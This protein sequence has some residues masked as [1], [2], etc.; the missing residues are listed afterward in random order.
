MAK[1][2][3]NTGQRSSPCVRSAQAGLSTNARARRAHLGVGKRLGAAAGP[4]KPGDIEGKGGAATSTEHAPGLQP[5]D[6]GRR[7]AR[8]PQDVVAML[9]D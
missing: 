6:L 4:G 5:L 1:L 9:P 8:F 7:I 2:Q 3:T